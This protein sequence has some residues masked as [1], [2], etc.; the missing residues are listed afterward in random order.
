M[1]TVTMLIS[2]KYIVIKNGSRHITAAVGTA[3]CQCLRS[4]TESPAANTANIRM[5]YAANT[6]HCTNCV[7]R[8]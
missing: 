7:P 3:M 2:R 1:Y 4:S 5:S 6:F 8:N